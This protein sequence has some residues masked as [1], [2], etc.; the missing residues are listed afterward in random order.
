MARIV[1]LDG[2]TLTPFHFDRPN[3]PAPPGEPTWDELAR[4]GDLTAYPRLPADRIVDALAGAEIALTNKARIDAAVID[5]L[6]DLR[7]I[8]VLA[9][10]VD[11][12]DLGAAR[13]RD[14]VVTNIPGYST[15]SVAQHV[16]ALLLQLTVDPASHGQAVCDGRW[17]TCPDFSFTLHPTAELAGR[18]LA[19]I[20]LGAIGM[21][22]A[23]IG[24]ALGMDLATVDRPR[25]S[26]LL[27]ELDITP[28]PLDDLLAHAD[29]VSLHCPLT[30]QTR[31]LINARRLAR[32]KPT[33]IL[34]NTGRGELI[35]EPALAE[36]LEHGRIAAAGLDVLSAE[37]PPRDHPLL[38][39]PRCL[40]T[41]H[42]AWATAEARRRLMDIAAA[43]V[44][45][46]L[47]G[48]PQNV[49]HA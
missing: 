13:R 33:A 2:Y 10:G 19:I 32:M 30:E 35:D 15:T 44:R 4:L 3:E 17:S 21:H 42:M 36:A 45:A 26:P 47:E 28:L 46:F 34:I 49:V 37:P 39:A 7:C 8:G 6:P 24:H 25:R 20:G 38:S 23:R 5:A 40:V 43:N 11:I 41:P 1:T 27:D 18:T 12:V 22:V 9:T 48:A 29:V 31:Q 14:V 16:F